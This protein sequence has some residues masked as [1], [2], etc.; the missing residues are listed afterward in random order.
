MKALRSQTVHFVNCK[1]IPQEAKIRFVAESASLLIFF[2]LLCCFGFHGQK[3]KTLYC[4]KSLQKQATLQNLQQNVWNQEPVCG[5]HE[6]I[7]IYVFS[8]PKMSRNPQLS[9]ESAN[10]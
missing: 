7:I 10:C 8:K 3:A 5:I 1:R 2:D 4:S 9:V 6:Q